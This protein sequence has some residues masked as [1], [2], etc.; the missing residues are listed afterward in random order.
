[1]NTQKKVRSS[2]VRIVFALA[3]ALTAQ[4]TQAGIV[5][6][7]HLSE[8]SLLPRGQ[9]TDNTLIYSSINKVYDANGDTQPL[10]AGSIASGSSITAVSLLLRYLWVGNIFEDTR[11]PYLNDHKQVFRVI[12]NLGH[13]QAGGDIPELSRKFGQRSGGSGIGDLFLLGGIYTSEYRWGPLKGNGLWATT[14]K[15][16]VGEYD[17]RSLL[18]IGTHYWS[19]IP[20]FAAHAEAFGRLYFDGTFAW[21]F[22]GHNDTP[23]YGGLTPTDP[24]D[25]RNLELNLA[26]K[27]SEKWYAD[28]GWSHRQTVG[29]N[30]YGKVTLNFKEPVPPNTACM[31]LNVPQAQCNLANNF[32]LDPV[33]GERQDRGVEG[34]LITGS[35]YYIYRSSMVLSLRAAVPVQGRGGQFN[36]DYDVYAGQKSALNNTPISRLSAPLTGV[37]EAAAVSASPFYELR[38]VYLFWAP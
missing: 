17:T 22:N 10:G 20:Q 27:F 16:P 35:L 38:M 4:A 31:L 8:Y 24:A 21:Q 19:V 32:S 15:L 30:R 28:A 11:V 7:P 18:N 9:Y 37:Q 12:G 36:M 13:Q 1:M 33:P 29:P 5:F 34:T 25:L 14:L 23:A 2:A 6:T 26:W 3:A